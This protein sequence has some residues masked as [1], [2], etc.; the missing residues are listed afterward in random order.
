MLFFADPGRPLKPPRTERKKLGS[1]KAAG[2]K[3]KI[4]ANVVRAFNVPIRQTQ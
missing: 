4:V 2:L 1:Q 3:V